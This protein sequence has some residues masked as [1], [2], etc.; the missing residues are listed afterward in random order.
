MSVGVLAVATSPAIDRIS[1]ARDT[2]AEGIVR[3]SRTLETPGGKAIHAAMVARALGV[4]VHLVAPAGGRRGEL[5][6]ELLADDGL[7][8]T[9][10][11]VAV[12]T[13]ATQTLV[14][15]E[16]GDRL[17]IH[18][19]PAALRPRE[20]DALVAATRERACGAKV[21][22]IAGGLPPAAPQDLHARLVRAAREGGAFTIL[23]SS[24]AE[25]LE[26]ALGAAPDLVKPNLAELSAL[27]GGVDPDAGI[28]AFAALAEG[29]RARGAGA[30]WVTLGRRGSVLVSPAGAL[31]FSAPEGRMVNAVGCGD[32]LA[33]GLAA[34]LA[35]GQELADAAALGVAAAADKLGRLHSG[36]VEPDLVELL[37]PR[38]ERTPVPAQAVAGR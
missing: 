32:A 10:L 3:A 6:R 15:A 16:L 26:L 34:G 25:A 27:L 31:H 13:R 33:G 1:L 9:L 8:S 14:D 18:D 4:S 22:V 12:E 20:C 38:V 24:S 2:P 5:L 36:R 17:E 21:V 7:E 19:P 37:L 30:V 23:D 11:T 35:Q 28:P 29:V